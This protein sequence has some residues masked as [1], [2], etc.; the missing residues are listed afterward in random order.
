MSPA[1]AR[2]ILLAFAAVY[3]IWGSTYLGIRFAVE[4]IPPF[5]M[6]GVRYGVAGALILAWGR[7]RGYPRPE[8]RHWRTALVVGLLMVLGGNGLLSWSEQYVPSGLAAL[9][10]ATVP[11]W[12]V[13]IAWAGPER[14][15]PGRLEAAGLGL[16]LVGVAV[17]ILGSGARVGIGGAST[18][19][20]LAGAI[21]VLVASFLWALGSMYSRR[22]EQAEPPIQATGLTMASGGLLLVA[23]GAVT[24]EAARLDVAGISARSW[25]A[26]AYLV[27]FGSVIAFSAYAWLLRHVRPAAVGTYAYVNPAVAVF[28]GWWLAGERLTPLMGLGMVGIVAA[29]VM[30]QRGRAGRPKAPARPAVAPGHDGVSGSEVPGGGASLPV[31]PGTSSSGLRTAPR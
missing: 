14:E 12:L 28:L 11:I 4:T 16:G 29:V 8:R 7:W 13:A 17:L 21:V 22:V 25:W 30:V 31:P 6:A 1:P 19:R 23:L 18:G 3:V 9:L 10:V 15:R 27:L 5:L 26:L 20:V 2:T 24:G